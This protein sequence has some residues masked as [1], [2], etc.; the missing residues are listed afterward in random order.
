MLHSSL[1]RLNLNGCREISEKSLVQISIQCPKLKRI[2]ILRLVCIKD[3]RAVLELQNHRLWNKENSKGMS[4]FGICESEWVQIP[5]WLINRGSMLVLS[6]NRAS[7]KL[8][9]IFFNTCVTVQNITRIPKI[10]DKSLKEVAT[11]SN[12]TYLNLYANAD[13][14]DQGFQALAASSKWM[15]SSP[16]IQ[17][18]LQKVDVHRYVRMQIS[19]WWISHSFDSE[20]PR[21]NLFKLSKKI[22]ESDY[23]S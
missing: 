17:Y 7:C 8:T 18:R 20:L 19:E 3:C 13:I 1:V 2:G 4:W 11:L 10:S 22:P 21:P 15:D 16:S 23:L 5:H 9:S 6:Q 12:L 14:P